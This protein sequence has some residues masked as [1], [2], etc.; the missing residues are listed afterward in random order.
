MRGFYR[1]SD[2]LIQ[3]PHLSICSKLQ[4]SHRIVGL[5]LLIWR[6]PQCTLSQYTLCSQLIWETNNLSFFDQ[7]MS[8]GSPTNEFSCCSLDNS[9]CAPKLYSF[10]LDYCTKYTIV[11]DNFDNAVVI[12]IIFLKITFLYRCFPHCF[13]ANCFYKLSCILS[14]DF[15]KPYPYFFF[16][17]LLL[18]Q[19]SYT[20]SCW[21]N[22]FANCH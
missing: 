10:Y 7:S 5:G 9:R 20:S 13:F 16:L 14:Y 3:M 22:V 6:M 15:A 18:L 21:I 11:S 17:Q 4:T 8:T 19:I 1:M 2:F 12:S